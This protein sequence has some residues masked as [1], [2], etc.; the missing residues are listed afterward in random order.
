MKIRTAVFPVAGLGTRFLPATKAIPKEML[1][2]GDKPLIQHA[3]E[4]AKSAGIE[5]FIFVT[6][7][8]K[9]AIEDH[10]DT[11]QLLERT[12]SERGKGKELEKV[13]S[14]QLAPGDAIFVRQQQ[15]LGLGH[16]V[17]CVRNLVGNEPFALLL[18]DDMIMG[19][20]PCIA[21]MIK[22]YEQYGRGNYTAVM[23]VE[24]EHVSRYGILDIVQDDGFIV[25]AKHVVEKPQPGQSP[26]KTAIVG[27]YI[28]DPM[29]FDTI[30]IR[31]L[32]VG[33][34]IQLTDAFKPMIDAGV[35]FYGVRFAGERYDCGTK[36]G[37]L[38]ANVANAYNN[39]EM[40]QGLLNILKK[41]RV[42][43]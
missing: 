37:W 36:D 31:N 28:L 1:I 5:R 25:K 24:P 12:L 35:P 40:R 14:L 7:Q 34:E 19:A 10:F 27:R 39:H 3:V 33:Q 2:V 20:A 17:W 13:Q 23:D 41:L 30:N 29:T 6:S 15:P 9:A 8:G 22:A 38:E 42:S 21:Q 26:S 43:C 16:A 32:G 11:N 18:A 4:E